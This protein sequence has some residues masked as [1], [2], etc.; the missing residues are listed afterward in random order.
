MSPCGTDLQETLDTLKFAESTNLIRST[1]GKIERNLITK[2][3]AI[4][5]W[6]TLCRKKWELF[7]SI[8]R[9]FNT[10]AYVRQLKNDF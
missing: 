7:L 9:F 2:Y 1:P 3:D 5:E 8:S 4:K 6:E 10:Y